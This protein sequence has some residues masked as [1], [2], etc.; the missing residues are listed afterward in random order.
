MAPDD[1]FNRLLNEKNRQFAA[2]CLEIG[3]L[4]PEDVRK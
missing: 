1:F 3:L 4:F 2:I